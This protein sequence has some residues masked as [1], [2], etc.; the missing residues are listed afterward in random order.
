[1]DVMNQP[2]THFNNDDDDDLTEDQNT[3]L[4]ELTNTLYKYPRREIVTRVKEESR[5]N[6]QNS[7]VMVFS[8]PCSPGG[9]RKAV[10]CKT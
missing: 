4:T 9:C 1:M 2:L 3:A 6:L 5:T 10:A 8:K 7:T